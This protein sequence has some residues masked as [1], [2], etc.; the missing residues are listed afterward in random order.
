[1]AKKTT[2][3]TI[4]KLNK[5][6]WR[7][8]LSDLRAGLEVALEAE[9]KAEEIRYPRGAAEAAL[10]LG[11]CYSYLSESKPALEHLQKAL[12]IYQELDEQEGSM[13]TLNAIGVVY[14]NVSQYES[15][16]EYYSKSL[17]LSRNAGNKEREL[18][19]INNLGEFY[20]ELGNYEEASGF[21][22]KAL[23]L[24][25]ECGDGERLANVLV[26][27]GLT[28]KELGNY[29]AAKEY[30]R[31]AV[32]SSTKEDDKITR[33]KC[34]TSM[35]LLYQ[36]MKQYAEAAEWHRKGIELSRETGNR[37]GELEALYN[38][39]KMYMTAQDEDAA[40]VHLQE[41]VHLSER[42][43]SKFYAYQAQLAMANMHERQG[44]YKTALEHFKQYNVI[45]KEVFSDEARKR[46]ENLITQH[47][48]ERASK[49]AEIFRLKNI[50]VE[51]ALSRMKIVS[52]I[53]RQITASLDI[54]K[55]MFTVY[56]NVNQL[57]AAEGFGIAVYDKTTDE[58]DYRLFIE[59]TKRMPREKRR[60]DPKEGYAAWCIVNKQ[61]V[62]I[63]DNEKEY[64]NYLPRRAKPLG[65][66]SESIIYVPLEIKN[67]I[68]GVLTVQSFS[69]HAYSAY[70]LDILKALGSYLAI[71]LENSMMYEQ[72]NQL[73]T[74]LLDEKK[75]LEDAN[76]QIAY[77]ANHDNLTGLPNRRLLYGLVEQVIPHSRRN[78][79][80]FALF[81]ID[82]DNFKP[83][84]DNFGHEVGDE[85]LKIASERMLHSFRA[86]DT[87]ARIGGDEFVA[88]IRDV[89]GK[90]A[91]QQ[92]AAKAIETLQAPIKVHEH[93]CDITVSIGIAIFPDNGATFEDL[94][95]KA[96]KAMYMAKETGK[97]G[98]CFY[99][100]IRK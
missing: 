17:A 37:H 40:L 84:N 65:R 52:E 2:R 58:I 43:G 32:K 33:V 69:K 39:S 23:E 27:L 16:L 74:L 92:V 83:I 3:A 70:H 44:D 48:I 54:E 90:K 19:A 79:T 76:K 42:I 34:C 72:V 29:T 80:E 8:M 21:F 11:W 86:S 51:N 93:S 62:V 55:I 66:S 82:L 68:I 99:S 1:V 100:S 20:H 59:E 36:D 87:V 18:A 96:D 10:N 35:G 95:K 4:D 75:D 30:L 31:K 53:G 81:Y 94:L 41:T 85:V 71:A 24:A 61:E 49:E 7:I 25:Q 46:L 28:Q 6:A 60:V 47:E 89:E 88:V 77:M 13:K 64:I 73:N 78:N 57:M 67:E 5:Q 98:Y 97:N 56:E 12:E 26:N 15:A 22:T 14:H 50:E 91:V 9:K 63:N 38:L 45:E